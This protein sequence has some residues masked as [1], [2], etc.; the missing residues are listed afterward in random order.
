MADEDESPARTMPTPATVGRQFNL[1]STA[2][3]APESPEHQPESDRE[4][5]AVERELIVKNGDY[6]ASIL[7]SVF[8]PE[9]R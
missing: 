8:A 3:S 1:G 9:M 5:S 6:L 7:T 4:F 2:A